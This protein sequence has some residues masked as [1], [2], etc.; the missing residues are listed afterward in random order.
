MEPSVRKATEAVIRSGHA[1]AQTRLVCLV[2]G[3]KDAAIRR[4]SIYRRRG[5]FARDPSRKPLCAGKGKIPRPYRRRCRTL[6]A[7][8]PKQHSL[9]RKVAQPGAE[10]TQS[11]LLRPIRLSLELLPWRGNC[12]CLHSAAFATTSCL[13]HDGAHSLAMSTPPPVAEA[14]TPAWR[15]PKSAI[16]IPDRTQR[17]QSQ[18]GG[19][20]TPPR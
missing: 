16:M 5:A 20:S 7:P 2:P 19:S 17:C 12:V 8:Y 14:G 10:F 11:Q 1:R 6:A 9:S 4:C 15:K 13:D 18:F 3:K